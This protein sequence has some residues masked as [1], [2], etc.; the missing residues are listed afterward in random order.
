M[1][2]FIRFNFDRNILVVAT[3]SKNI[4][5]KAGKDLEFFSVLRGRV[6]DYFIR[7]GISKH[8]N[9]EM[10]VKTIVL[11]LAYLLPFV[12]VLAIQ[13][14][15]GIQ[16][17]LW[18]VMGFALAGIGMSVMHDANHGAYSSSA[19]VN[20][21]IGYSLLLLGG[22]VDNWKMQHNVLHHTYTNVTGLDDDIDSKLI[23]R[24]SPHTDQK[25]VHKYQ[26][27]YA[28]L[29][30]SILTIYWGLLK[31]LVQFFRYRKLGVN[32]KSDSQNTAWLIRITVMKLL[33][34][35]AFLGLPVILTDI[36]FYQILL[37]FLLM[38]IIAGLILS[39]VFQ[40]A[41]TVEETEFPMPDESG[42]MENGWAIHQLKTTA[43]F[44]KNNRFISWYVGGLN[45]QVEHHLFPLICHVHYPAISTIVE[46]TAKEFG[47]AYLENKS[48]GSALKSHIALLR[49][50]GVP[51]L[52]EIMG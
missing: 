32:K 45:Y 36:P 13:P 7:N 28:F 14:G 18:A 24:F 47:V 43:N 25:K 40:L 9:T 23:L 2:K 27:Y 39:V 48:F 12:V 4:K 19:T 26:W 16:L 35:F 21:W 34:F 50:L 52:S 44:S 3:F 33:Y 22:A 41:H 29:F 5:F 1:W 37:G 8:A 46:S 15:F 31:D 42:N 10:V 38:H 20:K 11:L 49:K 51:R 17:V 6:D 30:Y